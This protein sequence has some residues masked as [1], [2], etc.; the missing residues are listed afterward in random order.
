MEAQ[1]VLAD[2]VVV[3]RPERRREIL[4][5]ETGRRRS[6]G[7]RAVVVQQR[8]KPDV[9]D[10]FGIPGH[11]DAPAQAVTCERDVAQTRADEGERLVVT[12]AR[13]YEILALRV[14]GF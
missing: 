14:Q 5:L 11:R 12:A 2:Q 1:D 9:E 4:A 6:E 3:G 13:A 8:V 10:V 7:E